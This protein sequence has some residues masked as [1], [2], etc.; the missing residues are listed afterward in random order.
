MPTI[1]KVLE[2]EQIQPGASIEAVNIVQTGE[3][4]DSLV[5]NQADQPSFQTGIVIEKP[6][7]VP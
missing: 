6:L 3:H 1:T 7:H 2:N 5:D 4:L